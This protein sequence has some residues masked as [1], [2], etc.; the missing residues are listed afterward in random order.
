MSVNLWDDE[1]IFNDMPDEAKTDSN[2]NPLQA[3][4]VNLPRPVTPQRPV[5]QK[6]QP[7]REEYDEINLELPEDFEDDEDF[8][9]V[10][11]DANLRLEQ[12]SLYKLIMKHELFEGID[13]DPKAVQ[14]VQ[15]AIRKFAR[16]QMEIMLG[17][18]KETST[19]EHLEIN[20][21][22]NHMEVEVLK[23]LAFTAT[24]GATQ[25]SDN[26]I[27]EVK[28]IKEEVPVVPKRNSLNPINGS[29]SKKSVQP[30]QKRLPTKAQTP[31]KRSRLD[32]TIDQIAREEGVP[33]ELL[34]E[35][36]MALNKPIHEMTEE[37]VINRNKQIAKR[38]TTQVKSSSALP[39]ATPEQ[40]EMLAMARASQ[41]SQG[42]GMAKILEAVKN[43]PIKS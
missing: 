1:E 30:P 23:K 4:P 24:K 12:G 26:Y 13:A 7:V 37:E 22:F 29:T 21:P 15:K 42:P 8:S 32:S 27:P 18:R 34:E 16:E 5:A 2:G 35:D 9:L 3:P 25:N 14:N 28:R 11:N 6:P 33:R 20:F 19:I 31:I 10:L 41:V 36:Y 17:M 40:Q 38:R 39:M 43:M